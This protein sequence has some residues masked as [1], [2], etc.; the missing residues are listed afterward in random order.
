MFGN[1]KDL[2]QKIE[3]LLLVLRDYTVFGRYL[4]AFSD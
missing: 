3:I 2:E 4:N 1:R